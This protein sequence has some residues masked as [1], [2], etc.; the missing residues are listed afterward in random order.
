MAEITIRRAQIKDID[1]LMNIL[2]QIG[3]IHHAIRPDL[4]KENLTKYTPEELAKIIS[5]DETP[6]FV[7]VDENGDVLGHMF[8]A[9]ETKGTNP[10]C[11]EYKTLYVDDLSMDENHRGLHIGKKMMDFAEEY[12]KENGCYN[13]TLHVWTGNDNA[14]RFYKS[15]GMKSQFTCMEK[16]L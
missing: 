14:E 2:V 12:A 15:I 11:H 9:F 3:N 4:F 1:K 5:N 6:V 16:I 10:V 7:A 13:V 8:C